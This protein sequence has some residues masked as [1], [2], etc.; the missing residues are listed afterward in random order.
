MPSLSA[1]DVVRAFEA[2]GFQEVRSK[3][4]HRILRKPGHRYH[5]SIPDHRGANVSPGVLR[6]SIAAA[7]M[8]LEEFLE[9]LNG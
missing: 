5:L 8:T 1:K 3:G 6:S 7:D 9:F 2:A 4:S